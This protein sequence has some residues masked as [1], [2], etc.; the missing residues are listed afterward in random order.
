[1]QK[2]PAI[3]DKNI[4]VFFVRFTDPLYVKM[5]KIDVLVKVA[6]N[7]NIDLIMS[8]LK[9]YCQDIELDFV[10]ASVKAIGLV[11]TKVERCAK[12]AVEILQELVCQEGADTALQEAVVVCNDIFRKYPN[13]FDALIRD[14][15]KQIKRINEPSS[16]SAM[17]WILGEYAEKIDSV[18]DMIEYFSEDF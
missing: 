18:E 17:I 15:C 2:Y 7:G 1:M 9:E 12:R 3:F 4:K 13:K 16:K 10:S 6:D 8:E 11:A 14:L 5:E